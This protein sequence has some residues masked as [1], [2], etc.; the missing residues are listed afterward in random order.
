MSE[1]STAVKLIVIIV[2]AVFVSPLLLLSL[3]LTVL[4]LRDIWKDIH[5]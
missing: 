3:G 4:I 2:T 5:R 1:G